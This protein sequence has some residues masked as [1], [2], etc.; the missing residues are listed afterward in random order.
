M[1][2]PP[3]IVVT[4]TATANRTDKEAILRRIKLYGDAIRRHGGDPI[5]LDT[6]GAAADREA[7]FA[8]MDGLVLSGGVD[9]D[10]ARYGHPNSGSVD[11][12]PDRDELEAK[13]WTAAAHRD[14]PV[15]GICRGFQVI[16]VLMGG[17]LLQHVESHRAGNGTGPPVRHPLHV[18]PGTRLARILFPAGAGGGVVEVNSFHHQAVRPADLAPGLVASGW[19]PS[20]AGE[21][22]EAVESPGTARLLLGV[23]CHPERTGSTPPA[24]E[25]MWS[26]FVDACRGPAADR[27]A[28]RRPT[29]TSPIA[30]RP[31]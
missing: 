31:G 29:V 16:N 15:L 13:A 20:P 10:P 3:R 21:L 23:Q 11:V 7:A 9:M 4:V 5:M 6:T 18:V 22:V 19:A 26:A 8:A 28:S 30:G 27:P 14:L 1:T 17:S 12:Q 2:P 24:F 25:R